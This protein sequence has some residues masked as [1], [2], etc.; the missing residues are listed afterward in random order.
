MTINYSLIKEPETSGRGR[1]GGSET[2]VIS[3]KGIADGAAD[4]RGRSQC[5]GFSSGSGAGK[6]F[7]S[8]Y[9]AINTRE[10]AAHGHSPIS[11]LSMWEGKEK[12]Y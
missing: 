11:Y 3:S 2:G 6:F 9:D 8:G 4:R 10:N 1:R 5:Q 12:L 7:I